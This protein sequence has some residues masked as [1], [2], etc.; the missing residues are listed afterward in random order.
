MKI[1]LSKG[2]LTGILLGAFAT[3][4]AD[5]ATVEIWKCKLNEGKTMDDV[6]TANGKWVKYMNASVKGGDILSYGLATVVGNAE[7]FLYSDVFP[8]MKAW[9]ASKAAIE[10]D[11]GQ[12]IEK[13]LNAVATCASNSLYLSTE[14]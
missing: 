8:D 2:L 6:A 3:A 11:E 12:A 5:T 1:L 10:S 14:H 13:E 7:M 4:Q 9:V